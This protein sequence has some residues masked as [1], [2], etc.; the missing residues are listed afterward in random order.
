MKL[1]IRTEDLLVV[2]MKSKIRMN[3]F[4]NVNITTV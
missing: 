1:L 2:Y 4:Q 3:L